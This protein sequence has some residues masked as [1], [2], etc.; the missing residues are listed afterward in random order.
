MQ[1]QKPPQIEPVGA[2]YYFKKAVEVVKL[3][4]AA[5]SDVAGDVN[6][7]RFGLVVTAIG[8]GLSVLSFASP[9]GLVVAAIYSVAALFLFSGFV[10]LT[11][12]YSKGKEEFM[13][14]VRILALSGIIDWIAIIPLLG[15]F[16]TVWSIVVAI[17]A[18]QQVYDLTKAKATICIILSVSALWLITTMLFTGPLGFLYE[19]PGP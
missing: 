12:G 14:F 1:T 3:N 19:T 7:I 2:L 16:A 11:A 4:R 6:A 10:H 8:G 13:G 5:M 18:A 15:L 17:H 9:G